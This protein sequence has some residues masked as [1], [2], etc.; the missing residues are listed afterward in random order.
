MYK[1]YKNSLLEELSGHSYAV[2]INSIKL[3]SPTLA[4][5]PS[6]LS[7]PIKSIWFERYWR[8]VSKM[9]FFLNASHYVKS[10]GHFCQILAFF[11]M[12]AH[13]IWSC[14]LTQQA[15]SKSFHFVLVLHLISGKVTTFLVGKLSTSKVISQNPHWRGV[16]N[17]P[18]PPPLPLGL[19]VGMRNHCTGNDSQ[20]QMFTLYRMGFRSSLEIY[21]IQCEQC[22]QKSKLTIP[23]RSISAVFF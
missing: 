23:D 5:Q 10:Y 15:I 11:T 8:E 22:S 17:A 18:P 9:Y 19:I 1:I 16:E 2:F 3:T 4:L 21:P 7:K 20:L 6:F 13:Q 14:Y 12:P